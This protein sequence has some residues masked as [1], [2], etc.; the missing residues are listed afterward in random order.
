MSITTSTTSTTITAAVTR[1]TKELSAD[2]QERARRFFK[3][4]ELRN[5]LEVERKELFES[6][7]N[8]LGDAEAGTVDGEVLISKSERTRESADLETLKRVAPEIADLVLRV[9]AYT[10]LTK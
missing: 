2:A 10:V 8:D 5:A 6:L 9:T 4:R 1:T 7:M 3:V